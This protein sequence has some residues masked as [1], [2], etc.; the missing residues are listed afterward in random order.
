[1][2]RRELQEISNIRRDE[3]LLLFEHG[4]Y[5]GAY[6]LLGYA[7]E[8][9]LKACIAKGIKEGDFPDWRF[10]RDSHTHNLASLL[11][12]AGLEN[13]FL[14]DAKT[15]HQLDLNWAIVKDRSVDVRYTPLLDERFVRKFFDSCIRPVDGVLP[16]IMGR[17]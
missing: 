6:Y 1:M 13:E 15:M 16:W 8:C 2:N 10:L 5:S 7:V 17:W 14:D 4:V 11:R 3:S 9:A 12:L